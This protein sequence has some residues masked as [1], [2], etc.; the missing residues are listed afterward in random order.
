MGRKG[1]SNMS[2]SGGKLPS[3]AT[4]YDGISNLP[5]KI[6]S[7]QRWVL[8]REFQV[9]GGP[10][11]ISYE[12]K[13]TYESGNPNTTAVN[14]QGWKSTASLKKVYKDRTNMDSRNPKPGYVM[15]GRDSNGNQIWEKIKKDKYKPVLVTLGLSQAS[16][17]TLRGI[18]QGVRQ[19]QK[20]NEANRR[21]VRRGMGL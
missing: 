18:E 14:G 2:E 3:N 12:G 1:K 10:I 7:N 8:Q 6:G 21:A 4:V 9:E 13:G 16:R 15:T 17:D 11:R 5:A 20:R 19:R